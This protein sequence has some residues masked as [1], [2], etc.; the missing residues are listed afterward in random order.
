M[1]TVL[2]L[3]ARVS[4]ARLYAEGCPQRPDNLAVHRVQPSAERHRQ[5][6]SSGRGYRK[7]AG[8]YQHR[9]T[10]RART[11]PGRES[12]A[13]VPQQ[14]DQ[15]DA[16]DAGEDEHGPLAGCH[17]SEVLFGSHRDC[18]DRQHTDHRNH[19]EGEKHP[20]RKPLSTM[21]CSAEDQQHRGRKQA[22]AHWKVEHPEA[23]INPSRTVHASEQQADDRPQPSHQHQTPGQGCESFLSTFSRNIGQRA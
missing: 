6:D 15:Q 16:D 4:R 18:D 5:C 20:E 23:V 12:A 1:R 2:G 21:Q 8:Q 11:E 19:L 9:A 7:A 14:G 22:R 3:P 13:P 17:V 10:N